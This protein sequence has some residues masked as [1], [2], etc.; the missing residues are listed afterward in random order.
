MAKRWIQ[1][2]RLET[3]PGLRASVP[4]TEP[5]KAVSGTDG[6]PLAYIVPL[7]GKGFVIVAGD[8]DVDPILYFSTN[9]LCSGLI[10][11]RNPLRA[12]LLVDIPQR[13]EIARKERSVKLAANA[14]WSAT[15]PRAP[16]DQS[17]L[18]IHSGPFM[19]TTWNQSGAFPTSEGG[20]QRTY[21]L[22]TPNSY[23]AGCVAVALGQVLKW[24]Q[25]PLRAS[26]EGDIE[27]DDNDWDDQTFNDTYDYDLMPNAL[28]SSSSLA[29]IQQVARLLYSAGI[30]VEME[31]TAS[32]SSSD[33]SDLEDVLKE[34]YGYAS[35][36][37]NSGSL[38]SKRD[39]LYNEL[40][41]WK[42]PAVIAI[43]DSAGNGHAIV[44]DGYATYGVSQEVYHFNMGW[45]GADNGWYVLPSFSTVQ[46]MFNW[47]VFRGVIGYIRPQVRRGVDAT[48]AAAGGS[49]TFLGE[50][51]LNDTGLSQSA[52]EP[53]STTFAAD[54]E[55]RVHNEGSFPDYLKIQNLVDLPEW[56][57]RFTDE[58]GVDVTA[59]VMSTGLVSALIRPGHDMRVFLTLTP[60]NS[61]PPDEVVSLRVRGSSH[62]DPTKRDTVI[63]NAM[64]V[65]SRPNVLV[66]PYGAPKEYGYSNSVP[67]AVLEA[68][69]TNVY[70]VI[71]RNDGLGA[72]PFYPTATR[73]HL[74]WDPV[75]YG[76]GGDT[77]SLTNWEVVWYDNIGHD[78]TLLMDC[79][80]W[81]TP[82]L[83]PGQSRYYRV[84]I[85]PR[86]EVAGGHGMRLALRARTA[87]R[88]V[89][90]SIA[91][92]VTK[93]AYW[94]ELWI[95]SD[96]TSYDQIDVQ[97]IAATNY[98]A[99]Y[100]FKL[101][102]AG[103]PNDRLTF[104][105]AVSGVNTDT[106]SATFQDL[107]EPGDLT[108]SVLGS[109]WTTD[110]LASG[111][112]RHVRLDLQ[113]RAGAIPGQ[114]CVVT[115]AV[116]SWGD[117]WPTNT[118]RALCTRGMPNVQVQGAVDGGS[119]QD[120]VAAT[121]I[122]T[123]QTS[124]FTV[125][126]TN[127]GASADRF[128]LAVHETNPAG[129]TLNYADAGSNDITYLLH[130][131]NYLT[132]E[133][134]PSGGYTDVHITLQPDSGLTNNAVGSSRLTAISQSDTSVSGRVWVAGIR[135]AYR[136]ELFAR[137]ASD[138]IYRQ[139]AASNSCGLLRSAVYVVDA[140]NYGETADGISLH[141]SFSAPSSGE[142]NWVVRYFSDPDG[143]TNVTDQITGGGW[144][145]EPLEPE[146]SATLRVEVWASNNVPGNSQ[147]V[148][149]LNAASIGSSHSTS[150]VRLVTEKVGFRPVVLTRNA[151]GGAYG[152]TMASQRVAAATASYDF[153]VRNDGDEDLFTISNQVQCTQWGTWN[154]RVLDLTANGTD[155]TEALSNG[156]AFYF[157]GGTSRIF[158]VEVMPGNDVPP[159][160]IC[161][162]ALRAESQGDPNWFGTEIALTYKA[163]CGVELKVWNTYYGDF[164]NAARDVQ[165]LP[166]SPGVYYWEVIN[167]G[168]IPDYINLLAYHT[169]DQYSEWKVRYYNN[170]FGGDDMTEWIESEPGAKIGPLNPGVR[171]YFR[172]EAA[173][174]NTVV[175]NSQCAIHMRADADGYLGSSAYITASNV[176][177][178]AGH[179]ETRIGLPSDFDFTG[180]S[181]T[182]TTHRGDT[183]TFVLLIANRS[184]AHDT[185]QLAADPGWAGGN[186]DHWTLRAFNDRYAGD[187]VTDL[188]LSGTLG[189]GPFAK[190]NG[191]FM[192]LE[193][194][195][196]ETAAENEILT[197]R[198]TATS[199][200]DS[201][202]SGEAFAETHEL[203]QISFR[204]TGF[205][206]DG[207]TRKVH[208]EWS[209]E[210]G[211]LYAI[212]AVPSLQDGQLFTPVMQNIQALSESTTQQ[213]DMPAEGMY[214]YRVIKP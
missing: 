173:P 100:F 115:C 108:A 59:A 38:Q 12:L 188:L 11:P 142:T 204:I 129:W 160:A 20:V 168:E 92:D 152:H 199:L 118:L 46:N 127:R 144:T 98:A 189:Y 52:Y 106:W 33:T 182:Q 190:D 21:N 141:A 86:R 150:Q 45:G 65:H 84:A 184:A 30:S 91:I 60:S 209:S 155:V 50:N 154:L 6:E 116:S 159:N 193:V 122:P 8:T 15:R 18:T 31:Y 114:T 176:L 163:R 99:S 36:E 44:A 124:N 89:S 2:V 101:R 170:S 104:K 132:D 73:A 105:A 200:G 156:T 41:N 80:W 16:I 145:A 211:D 203:G 194:M 3:A 151:E 162:Y 185:F 70:H 88:S 77:Y 165:A 4:P 81:W 75:F 90:D 94:P 27:V 93:G 195:P 197:L 69:Q 67:A 37:W 57:E 72:E 207:V 97:K 126:I 213:V 58:L 153:M 66:R 7:S 28:D 139:G 117:V 198:I 147:G 113:P 137:P 17:L 68:Q 13:Q 64:V 78:V 157:A 49:W 29:G 214:L 47:T 71:I 9:S 96:G 131:G 171:Y 135:S 181:V 34:V 110:W 22:Y 183:A 56:T 54:F 112:E 121:R 79:G 134:A 95:S 48:I 133:I 174:S 24:F 143:L 119:W 164:T 40:Y 23:L 32:A 186:P 136:A 25:F 5:P 87:D 120:E 175:S 111:S 158:R 10:S 107:D 210:P 172:S 161:Q 123:L 63:A 167:T 202:A 43:R 26:G 138:P 74:R 196:M 146:S 177:R 53:A 85:S 140:R 39:W 103:S 178:N 76:T 82:T 62:S 102:N 191:G 166:S 51:I 169:S 35:A 208:I 125:R 61:V 83:W 180:H 1:E 149:T 205:A 128:R 130:D 42:F 206:V 212:E 179:V 109:G 14:R 201:S 19:D 187:D 148:V 55:I 192:R